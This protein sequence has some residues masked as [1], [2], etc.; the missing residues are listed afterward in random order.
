MNEN[1]LP[2]LSDVTL[3]SSFDITPKEY[4]LLCFLK[5]NYP[6]TITN[7]YSND[8]NALSGYD[9]YIPFYTAQKA[10]TIE[11]IGYKKNKQTSAKC[12]IIVGDSITKTFRT[13]IRRPNV[14]VPK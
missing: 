11:I 5:E 1:L 8:I 6:Y 10:Y 4:E 3:S 7:K 12:I 9:F 2:G 14:S 13:R